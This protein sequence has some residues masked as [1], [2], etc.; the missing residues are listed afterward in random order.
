M[1]LTCCHLSFIVLTVKPLGWVSF[2]FHADTY[3]ATMEEQ[4]EQNINANDEQSEKELKFEGISNCILR[5]V[6]VDAEGKLNLKD[7]VK[8][9]PAILLQKILKERGHLT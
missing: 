6:G 3:D 5:H 7:F 9:H 2:V 4:K 8:E 1:E